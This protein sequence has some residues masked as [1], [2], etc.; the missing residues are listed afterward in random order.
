MIACPS[1]L[2]SEYK[3]AFLKGNDKVTL[4]LGLFFKRRSYIKHK[5]YIK[6]KFEDSGIFAKAE[7]ITL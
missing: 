1:F 2:R 4:E 5:L 3:K 6:H 7:I